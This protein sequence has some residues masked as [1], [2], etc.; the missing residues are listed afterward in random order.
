M[1]L[2]LVHGGMALQRKTLIGDKCARKYGLTNVVLFQTRY[3]NFSSQTFAL[4]T[5]RA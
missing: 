1:L 4:K 2:F 5:A 3:A